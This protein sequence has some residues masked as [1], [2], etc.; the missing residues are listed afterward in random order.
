MID[1][2]A[3]HTLRTLGAAARLRGAQTVIVGIEP[4]V[5]GIAMVN[6]GLALEAAQHPA[7][8]LE[9]GLDLPEQHHRPLKPRH[10]VPV[11]PARWTPSGA[12]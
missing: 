5:Y 10:W 4:T 8:D 12:T 1:S 7:L 11:S 6:L 9:E 3:S 2:F